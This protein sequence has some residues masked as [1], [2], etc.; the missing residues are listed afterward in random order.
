MH[1]TK[2]GLLL[3]ELTRD[4]ASQPNLHLRRTNRNSLHVKRGHLRG[5]SQQLAQCAAGMGNHVGIGTQRQF[6][7]HELKSFDVLAA[8]SNHITTTI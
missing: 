4:Y 6:L 8:L 1:V 2:Q 7:P 5:A 3:P